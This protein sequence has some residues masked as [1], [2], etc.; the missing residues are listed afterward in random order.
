MHKQTFIKTLCVA[1]V[2]TAMTGCNEQNQSESTSDYAMAVVYTG[3]AFGATQRG[4]VLKGN[5]DLYKFDASAVAARLPTD[6]VVTERQLAQVFEGASFTYVKT[7][8]AAEFDA[9]VMPVM[10]TSNTTLG[11]RSQICSDAGQYLYLRFKPLSSGKIEQIRLYEAGDFRQLQTDPK[12][13][14]VKQLLVQQALTYQ[15]ARKIDGDNQSWCTG[16]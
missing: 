5:G 2:L 14:P 8:S 1:V 16:M 11:A 7:L 6:A 9:L 3:T 15:I 10:Q 4:L 13:E 12:V